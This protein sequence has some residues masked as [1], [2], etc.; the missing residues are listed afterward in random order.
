MK[1]LTISL[2]TFLLVVSVF[3]FVPQEVSAQNYTIATVVKLSG[4]SWFERMQVGVE[5]FAE[6]TGH[7]AYQIG[8]SKADVAQQVKMIEDLI[9]QDVDAITVVPNA[10]EGLEPVL[11]KAREAGIVVISHEG[12]GLKNVDYDV[13]PFRHSD[14][15]AHFMDLLAEEM[16]EKGKYAA[17]VGSL[18][19]RSHNQ[20]IDAAVER[21]KNKYPEMEM[22]TERIAGEENKTTVY[23]KTKELFRTYPEVKGII[24]SAATDPAG[25]GQAIEEFGIE[26]ETSVVGTSIVSVSGSYI[27]SGAVDVI[28]FWDPAK[29]GYVMNQI[30]VK[31]LNGEK[32]ETGDDLGVKG[33][34]DVVVGDDNVIRGQAWVDVDKSN[35]DDYDF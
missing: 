35:V 15:G 11:R 33:Y 20:W 22:V 24:G 31:V 16:N 4:V 8:P 17:F 9:A 3:T 34:G 30:A 18:T 2:V 6:D 7:D 26:D 25:A 21:Q 28:S 32:I 13:E 14:Y 12:A 10:V 23:T 27:K 29:A 1:K 19:A 5:N